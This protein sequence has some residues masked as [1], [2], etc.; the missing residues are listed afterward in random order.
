MSLFTKARATARTTGGNDPVQAWL[1]Q[2]EAA[3]ESE[4]KV[5][6]IE[7]RAALDLRTSNNESQTQ[8]RADHES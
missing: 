1:Q 4:R 8:R 3:N 5:M 2:W 6:R 7:L